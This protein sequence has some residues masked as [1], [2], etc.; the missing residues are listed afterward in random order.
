MPHDRKSIVTGTGKSHPGQLRRSARKRVL[1]KRRRTALQAE[2][3]NRGVPVRRVEEERFE[4]ANQ[5]RA[6]M[7]RSGFGVPTKEPLLPIQLQTIE[8][9]PWWQLR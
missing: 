4:E 2:A 6:V 3:A 8:L 1:Q 7:Q 9:R 5:A